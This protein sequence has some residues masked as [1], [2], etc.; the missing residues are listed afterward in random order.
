MY[1]LPS[2]HVYPRQGLDL[3][4]E[5]D[6]SEPRKLTS[7][8]KSNSVTYTDIDEQIVLKIR[9]I[10]DTKIRDRISQIQSHLSPV[11]I[12]LFYNQI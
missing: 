7:Y 12:Y 4:R 9:D 11:L 2:G 5:R 10:F 6:S 8:D 1:R 3:K